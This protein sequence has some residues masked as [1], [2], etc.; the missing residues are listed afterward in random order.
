MYEVIVERHTADR[1]WTH[2]DALGGLYGWSYARQRGAELL[3]ENANV[4]APAA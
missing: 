4:A 3:T 2:Q 1:C